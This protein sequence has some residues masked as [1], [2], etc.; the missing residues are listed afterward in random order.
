[1]RKFNLFVKKFAPEIILFVVLPLISIYPFLQSRGTLLLLDMQIF[2]PNSFRNIS[3]IYG[4][5]TPTAGGELPLVLIV[6]L[7]KLVFSF[8]HVQEIILFCIL[9]FAMVNCYLFSPT[10][11]IG[12][13]FAA[14]MFAFNPFVYVRILMG[15]WVILLSYAFIPLMLW[16]FVNYL[17]NREKETL[18]LFGLSTITVAINS[19]MLIIASFIVLVLAVMYSITQSESYY[20]ALGRLGQ[21]LGIPALVSFFVNSYWLIPLFST[22]TPRL[23]SFTQGDLVAF[24]PRTDLLTPLLSI[25]SLH[26][27]W[28]GG[29]RY[30]INI[31]PELEFLFPV[32][33]FLSVY[34]A[35]LLYSQ[36]DR[37]YLVRSLVLIG[38]LSI[39]FGAG[40]EAPTEPIFKWLFQHIPFFSGFRDPQKFVAALSLVY[41]YFGG[42]SVDH[43]VDRLQKYELPR[44]RLIS[45]SLAALICL[46]PIAY[47]FPMVTGYANQ[48]NPVEYPKEWQE[49]DTYLD[50]HGQDQNVLFLPWHQYMNYSWI[51]TQPPRTVSPARSYFS[52]PVIQADN[53]EF[54]SV[55]SNTN[56]PV[57]Q[58]V[59][60][61]FGIG[62]YQSKNVDRLGLHLSQINVEYVLVTKETDWKSYDEILAEQSDLQLVLENDLFKVYRNEVK[63]KQIR[64]FDDDR[65]VSDWDEYLSRTENLSKPQTAQISDQ[66][67]DN[68]RSDGKY[69]TAW[70]RQSMVK[71]RVDGGSSQHTVFIPGPEM[72]TTGWTYNNNKPIAYHL[73]F[74]PVFESGGDSQGNMIRFSEFYHVYLPSYIISTTVII[75]LII[76]ISLRRLKIR[77]AATPEE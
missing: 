2:G 64:S 31:V 51:G 18:G 42:V 16:S 65:R 69:E 11:R 49:V 47:T 76:L 20:T 38:G 46:T 9:F 28:Q 40:I 5:K 71:Y 56:D 19:H 57:S 10:G 75:V 67:E 73:G 36:S 25:A 30:A 63:S 24:A 4:F 72:S 52:T 3:Y 8:Q 61:L 48:A 74:I 22:G 62:P 6:E 77:R 44:R 13:I 32:L 29:Y 37:R 23:N 68:E 39:M 43:I 66:R 1:M 54:Q 12:K 45:M 58:Y 21:N 60:Y 27:T 41:A 70:T 26:G 53:L 33:L 35:S 17:E 50:E 7:L 59:E 15:H 55:Y 34:G 14:V